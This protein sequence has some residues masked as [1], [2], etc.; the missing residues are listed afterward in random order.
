MGKYKLHSD[1]QLANLLQSGDHEAYT[2]IYHRFKTVLYIHAYNKLRHTEEAKDLVQDLFVWLWHNRADFHL[3]EQL[4]SY[5]YKAVRNRVFRIIE[6]KGLASG[7]IASIQH[8]IQA[9][10]NI[11]DHRVRENLLMAI[12]NREVEALPPKMKEIFLLSRQGNLSHKEIADALGIADVTVKKQINNAL[13]ILRSR[14]G[15]SFTLIL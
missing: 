15:R 8:S 13:R 7:H 5:L 9:G 12:V 4:S 11:T 1:L 6:R 3:K 10:N 2:E 14:L